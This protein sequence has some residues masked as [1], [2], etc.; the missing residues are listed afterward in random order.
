MVP[1]TTILPE[2]GHI[3]AGGLWVVAAVGSAK[4]LGL[5][6]G[7]RGGRKGLAAL[8]FAQ[9]SLIVI[10]AQEMRRTMS[11]SEQW[12]MVVSLTQYFLCTLVYAFKWPDFAP[13]HWGYHENFHLLVC[14]GSACTYMCAFS[15]VRRLAVEGGV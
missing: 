12:W 1:C 8:Y 4:T 6:P 13:R 2:T 5:L 15:I 10:S 3:F 14:G 9:G 7:G 11:A